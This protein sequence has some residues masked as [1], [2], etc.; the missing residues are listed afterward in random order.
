MP[1]VLDRFLESLRQSGLLSEEEIADFLA[2]LGEDERPVT[3]DDLAQSLHRHR[4]LTRFQIQSVYQGKTKGLVLGNYVV[5]DK[6]GQGGMG[7]VY[8]AQHRR[9]KR[10]VALKVLPS[11]VAKSDKA[12]ERFQREVEAAARL[13]HPHVVTAY[14]ANQA[15]GIHFLVME[16]VAGT[17]L[18]ALVRREGPLPV[19]TALDYVLQAARGLAYAHAQGVIH[20]DIKPSNL[21][22]DPQGTVKVLDLGLAR[23]PRDWEATPDAHALTEAGQLL[24]T[25][26]FIAPEQAMDTRSA[27]ARSDIYSL[28]CT[29]FY[30]L[31]GRAVYPTGSFPQKIVDHLKHPIPSLT[32]VG[33]E[34]PPQVDAVFQRLVA[35]RPE[36]RPQSMEEVIA[37][38]ESCRAFG[39]DRGKASAETSTIFRGPTGGGDT[40]RSVNTLA[41]N[42]DGGTPAADPLDEWCQEELPATPT[43]LRSQAVRKPG[44]ERRRLVIGAI[45]VG[46]ALV[47]LLLF[48]SIVALLR[49]DQGTLVVEVDE[50]G[51]TVQVLD[52]EGRIVV[53][54]VSEADPL[55]FSLEP[56]THRLRVEKDGFTF[57]AQEFTL[58]RRGNQ[59]IRARLEPVPEQPGT[60]RINVS[61]AGAQVELLDAQGKVEACYR[62]GAEEIPIQ[63]A[64]GEYRLLIEK[65]GFERY[66]TVMTVASGSDHPVS[67]AL[68]ENNP[69]DTEGSAATPFTP[70]KITRT[71]PEPPPAV[72]PFDAEQARQHQEVWAAQLGIPVEWTNSIGM[73]FVLIPPGEFAMGSTEQDVE[74]LLIG[75]REGKAPQG[76]ADGLPWELSQQSVRISQPFLMGACEVTI[77]GFRQFVADT[78][79]VT[80]AE[81][82]GRGGWGDDPE[83]GRVRKQEFTWLYPRVAQSDDHPVVHVSWN[84]AFTFCSWLSR[85]EGVSY[86]LPTEAEWEYACRAGTTTWYSCGDDFSQ[87]VDYAW[88]GWNSRDDWFGSDSNGE[89]HPVGRKKANPWGLYDM[90][91][92]V[93]EWCQ[94]WFVDSYPSGLITDPQGPAAGPLRVFRGG[95]WQNGAAFTRSA[96]RDRNHPEYCNNDLGFRVALAL[97][98]PP[99]AVAP[100]LVAAQSTP[101]PP[102]RVTAGDGTTGSGIVDRDRQVAMSLLER[103]AVVVI[104]GSHVSVE[105]KPGDRL[106]KDPFLV[107]GVRWPD[108]ELKAED[109]RQLDGLRMLHFMEIKGPI[110]DLAGQ[111]LAALRHVRHLELPWRAHHVSDQDAALLRACKSLEVVNFAFT[112]LLEPNL[113]ALAHLPSLRHVNFWSTPLNDEQTRHLRHLRKLQ[114]LNLGCT[115]VT[116]D[117]LANIRTMSELRQLHLE[118]MRRRASGFEHLSAL[119]G[120]RHLSLWRSRCQDDDLQHLAELRN[121]EHLNVEGTAITDAGLAHLT[122]A[123]GLRDL[124]LKDTGITDQGL[125]HLKKLH[126]LRKVDLTGTRVTEQGR[127]GLRNALP[128]CRVIF[129]DEP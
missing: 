129:A 86:R 8:Q 79:Y 10:I 111:D 127:H 42:R 122:R 69:I 18:S 16:Y 83:E 56:G 89:S 19:A 91:G 38:L 123:A 101:M 9:M 61:Q 64:P 124:Y 17:D 37:E 66:D 85:K 107:D 63:V 75:I 11:A 48:G 84:D 30:L 46:V 43:L 121:L 78:G 71:G 77:G 49:T 41:P 59:V 6:I 60:V 24:G 32:A 22:L 113:Q 31:T 54:G 100:Q 2:G 53:R 28:G 97:D 102:A 115:E 103:G 95:S 13:S 23:F 68:A 76:H 39:G 26:D 67:V 70:L 3:G 5:L 45:G 33:S 94:D 119:T 87:L 40:E 106:P 108:R 116:S 36:E 29:L 120:L 118:G 125:Q 126:N 110:A 93:Y 44:V 12:I 1:V 55:T 25:V 90:H 65:S 34:V 88:Y 4:K 128:A 20:R 72:A 47:G 105:L 81:R 96:V 109:L 92:N 80:E 104:R 15:D 74:R 82:D 7:H 52:A 62:S 117:G 58:E 73:K 99:S 112:K 50:L 114:F 27:D 57:F 98:V 35:K 51:A 14:D 21:L